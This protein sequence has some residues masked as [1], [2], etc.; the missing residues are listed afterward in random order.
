MTMNISIVQAI[1]K[2]APMNSQERCD[3][4]SG[5]HFKFLFSKASAAGKEFGIYEC[6]SCGVVQTLPRP[7]DAELEEC[8]G[9]HYFE[10]RTDRGYDNYFSEAMRKQL[11]KVWSLNLDDVG[12]FEFERSLDRQKMRALDVGCA[13]GYFVDYMR[14]R[15][16]Q[17]EGIEL[18]E[19]A[20]RAGME[21]LGLT[22]H[23]Q[24]FLRFQPS[25]P[26]DLITLWASIEH[27]RSPSEALRKISAMLRPG[28][29]LILSTCRWGILSRFQ[30]PSWRF[31]NVPEHL[32]YFSLST[33]EKLAA[34]Y[35]LKSDGYITYGSGFTSYPG[36][37]PL[38]RMAKALADRTVKSMNQGD[39][40]VYAFEKTNLHNL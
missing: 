34:R 10:N 2:Q 40:M 33:L 21:Q 17:A 9:S 15:G 3:A 4:C 7:T 11:E 20:A 27:L 31:L 29:R 1:Q 39:M 13:A 8:Y 25:E 12:F 24:D 22:I 14:N 36:M 18:S 26:Y 5:D 30:G 28:G 16:W 6:K 37:G 32:F 19:A 38:Y 35:G 23:I